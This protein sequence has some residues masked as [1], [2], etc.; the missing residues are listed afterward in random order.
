MDSDRYNSDEENIKMIAV[1]EPSL[2]DEEKL[3][4]RAYL[5]TLS[6]S[7][8]YRALNPESTGKNYKNKYS[9]RPA[10]LYHINK[11]LLKRTESLNLTPEIILSKMYEEATRL[12]YGTSHG[13]RITALTLLGKHMGLFIDEKEA[14]EQI[15]Y[16]IINYNSPDDISKDTE[17]SPLTSQEDEVDSEALGLPIQMDAEVLITKYE[18][19]DG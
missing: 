3:Y 7:L 5:A 17:D 19:E 15:T 8:A 13:S 4:L 10:L 16:N 2:D 1:K 11:E 6:H 12:G 9:S 18:E 14:K